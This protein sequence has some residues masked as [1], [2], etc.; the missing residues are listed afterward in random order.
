MAEYVPADMLAQ[1][2]H[3]EFAAVGTYERT[4][5][6][7]TAKDIANALRAQIDATKERIEE[8]RE[9]RIAQC[10]SKFFFTYIPDST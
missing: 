5:N 7:R 1:L 2:P 8:V 6:E 10:K 4:A 3:A 9:H